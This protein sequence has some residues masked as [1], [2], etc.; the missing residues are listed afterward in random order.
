MYENF[1]VEKYLE[2]SDEIVVQF[3]R[4]LSKAQSEKV[5]SAIILN[6]NV[7]D[8]RT[9]TVEDILNFEL[10]V[11]EVRKNFD[12]YWKEILNCLEFD[13]NEQEWTSFIEGVKVMMGLINQDID[14]FL[15]QCGENFTSQIIEIN[16]N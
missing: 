11:S 8:L 15:D 4:S 3:A 5:I 12:N 7:S 14:R 10:V 13:D 16:R 2:G 9:A 1:D 6:S